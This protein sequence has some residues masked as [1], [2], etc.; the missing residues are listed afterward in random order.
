MANRKTKY[1]YQK[2]LVWCTCSE[3]VTAFRAKG[4]QI[5]SYTRRKHLEKDQLAALRNKTKRPELPVIP[6]N[7]TT[8]FKRARIGELEAHAGPSDWVESQLTGYPG[9]EDVEDPMLGFEAEGPIAS[10]STLLP[11]STPGPRSPSPDFNDTYINP[12]YHFDHQDDYEMQQVDDVHDP[13]DPTTNPPVPFEAPV[14]PDPILDEPVAIPQD[15]MQPTPSALPE[16]VLEPPPPPTQ[17]FQ[18]ASGF[19]FWRIILV[20]TAWLHLHYHVPHRACTLLL[21]VLRV[22]FIALG[23]LGRNDEAPVTL[24]TTFR[25]LRFDQQFKIYPTCPQCHDI[26]PVDSPETLKCSKCSIA[27]FKFWNVIDKNDGKTTT[28]SK[29]I[30]QTPLQTLSEQLPRL[31]NR[32]GVEIMCDEWRHRESKPGHMT[33]IMDGDI[34]KTLKGHDG[35]LFFDNAIDHDS[36]EELRLGITLG[37]DGFGYKNARSSSSYS[38]SVLSCCVANLPTHYRYRPR[39]LIIYGLTPGPT[40]WDADEIQVFQRRFV[41]DLVNLYDNGVLI[42]TPLFPE[43][44]RVRVA[45]I[46]VCCDHPAMCRM[47]GF[48]DHRTEKMFCTRC[49]L[50]H[51]E[52]NTEAAMKDSAAPRSGDQHRMH[53][54]EYEKLKSDK[55]RQ[56]FFDM[57]STR[58]FDLSRLTYFDPVRMTVIDPMH[59]ILLGIIKN[60][61]LNGWIDTKALR[62]RT[63]TKKVP[64]ELDQIHE[65]LK[66]FEMPSW[67]ARLP[68]Q[69]GYPAGGS[70]STDEWKCLGL[71]YG[72]IVVWV[73]QCADLL[74][75]ILS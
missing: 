36:P 47:C 41:T 26:F 42:K 43:G 57:F 1:D 48:G 25:R 16:D 70:L 13:L 59:N 11:L 75:L 72:P 30:L 63:S 24:T 38:S 45:L 73:Y 28:R 12:L 21:K 3:C 7:E 60:Q 61:W 52:L 32:H 44:R 2:Q 9:G 74:M 17:V 71:V 39:N 50:T 40:E 56:A 66:V 4:Q 19:W 34:W 6:F 31:L 46:A 68:S 22:I 49:T 29:P 20:L 18:E 65:Y 55:A 64:R 67:V 53:A 8:A 51:R 37:F 54:Q 62:E 69:V 58:Y 14:N 10:S 15:P 5:K 35:K 33:H 23:Q 27:V